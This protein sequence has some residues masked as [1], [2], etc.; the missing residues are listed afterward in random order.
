MINKSQGFDKDQSGK[1]MHQFET[2]TAGDLVPPA[3]LELLWVPSA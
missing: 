3:D 1:S 2:I